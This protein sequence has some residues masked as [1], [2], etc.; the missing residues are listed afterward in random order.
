MFVP[1]ILPGGFDVKKIHSMCGSGLAS[2]ISSG[3]VTLMP[4]LDS[5]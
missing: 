2:I 1:R 4:F 3:T 5:I